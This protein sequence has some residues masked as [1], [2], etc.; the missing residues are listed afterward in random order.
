MKIKF[1]R[2]YYKKATNKDVFVYVVEGT[3]EEVAKYEAAQGEN[4][5]ID[6]KINKP[7]WFT[8]T[9]VGPEGKLIVTD[10]NK[11]YAD[12]SEIKLQASF[13]KSLGG[14]LGEELA[15]TMAAKMVSGQTQSS[16]AEVKTETKAP[17]GEF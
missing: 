11:V 9:S 3:K 17:I 16:T 12:M 6:D 14:N 15:K 1:L 10:E 13:I 5:V 4:L 8:T 7:L 2:T